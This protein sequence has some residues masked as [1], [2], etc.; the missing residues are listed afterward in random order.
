MDRVGLN[1]IRPKLCVAIVSVII[2]IFLGEFFAM[3]HTLVTNFKNFS[4]V[5]GISF[6][7]LYFFDL[8]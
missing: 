7:S 2:I 6:E 8:F 5:V 3:L 1:I 4:G